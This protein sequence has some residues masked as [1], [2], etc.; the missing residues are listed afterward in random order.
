M[1]PDVL[2]LIE[3]TKRETIRD[4]TPSQGSSNRSFRR[5]TY[6]LPLDLGVVMVC[7]TILL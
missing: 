7:I 5:T 1:A 6:D 4:L 3:G 2:D